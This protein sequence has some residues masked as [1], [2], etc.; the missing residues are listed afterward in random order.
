MGHYRWVWVTILEMKIIKTDFATTADPFSFQ[1]M[2]AE[3]AK[4]IQTKRI[5]EASVT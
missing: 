4:Y 5:T 3:V 2:D 1:Y